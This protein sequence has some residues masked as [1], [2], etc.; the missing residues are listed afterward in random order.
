MTAEP[1]GIVDRIKENVDETKEGLEETY[2]Q[3]PGESAGEKVGGI[4]KQAVK[5]AK[6]VGQTD[7]ED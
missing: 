6:E 1:E 2:K 3:Q 4:F 7:E 5:D